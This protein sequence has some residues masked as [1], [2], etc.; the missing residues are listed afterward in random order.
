MKNKS[1]DEYENMD[2]NLDLQGIEEVIF[3]E[4]TEEADLKDLPVVEEK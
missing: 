1:F 4:G 2:I 3:I